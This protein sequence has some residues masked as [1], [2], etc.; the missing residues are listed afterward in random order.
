MDRLI[1]FNSELIAFFQTM[2]ATIR[3]SSTRRR[4]GAM[5]EAWRQGRSRSPF[6]DFAVSWFLTAL[7]FVNDLRQPRMCASA[8][9]GSVFE[10][11]LVAQSGRSV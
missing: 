10:R 3:R 4:I 5:N 11:L 2:L 1:A 8:K 7:G 6:G 9:L